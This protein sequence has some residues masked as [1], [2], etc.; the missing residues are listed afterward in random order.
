MVD[1]TKRYVV[2]RSPILPADEDLSELP[3]ASV[4]TR[5]MQVN[6][7]ADS[8]AADDVVV[9]LKAADGTYAWVSLTH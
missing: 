5:G 7:L 2:G 9:C 1:I 6:V 3:A 8:G 4:T